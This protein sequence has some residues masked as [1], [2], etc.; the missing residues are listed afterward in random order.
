VQENIVWDGDVT[1]EGAALQWK[2]SAPLPGL[3]G[4][5]PVRPFANIGAFQI[6]ELNADEGDPAVFGFQAGSDVDLPG[7][8]TFQ[9]SVAFYDFTA[10]EG[11]NVANVANAPAGNSTIT[12][13]A[14]RKFAKDYNILQWISK[15]SVP[16]VLG[17]PVLLVADYTHNTAN[18]TIVT[19]S[20]EENVDDD[21]AWMAGIEIG[22][23]TEK[24]GSWKA[25]YYYKRLKPDATFGAIS[26]SDFGAGGTNHKGHIMG[27][28]LGLN[29]YA[30]MGLKYFRTDEV[31]GSQNKVDTFQADLQMK[32]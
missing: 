28:Q 14:A 24:F 4:I 15:L 31:E 11:S 21:G 18:K 32:F 22:K 1:P 5:L 2:S 10:I 7:G 9:P 26:D 6:S 17:Q 27:I 3:K 12:Q 8:I 19:G 13:G 16:E 23:V 30:S 29:K 20:D 25:A